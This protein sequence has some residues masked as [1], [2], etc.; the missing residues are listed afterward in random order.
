MGL[1]VF[2]GLPTYIKDISCN[3]KE[4]KPLLKH[5]LYPNSFYPM[6]EY[7]QYNNTPYILFV[8]YI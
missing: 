2:N 5:F 3:V 7:L 1:K 6:E 8:A 4:F